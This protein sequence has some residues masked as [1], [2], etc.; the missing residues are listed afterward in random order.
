MA[1]FRALKAVLRSISRGQ[2]VTFRSDYMK[3]T[4]YYFLCSHHFDIN[5]ALILVDHQLHTFTLQVCKL[6]QLKISNYI[7]FKFCSSFTNNRRIVKSRVRA[8]F[9]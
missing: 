2:L 9:D 8:K 6:K 5:V 1:L 3:I 7:I 4:S